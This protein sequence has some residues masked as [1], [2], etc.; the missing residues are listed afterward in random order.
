PQRRQFRMA[1]DPGVLGH[2]HFR[3]PRGDEEQIERSRRFAR[4]EL[5]LGSREIK[6]ALWMMNE[7]GPAISADQPLNRHARA[8]RAQLVSALAVTHA[9]DRALAVELRPALAQ[10][11]QRTFR[12]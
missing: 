6:R 1:R 10:S 4:R 2:D 11:P 3:V 7:H 12:Q 9:I 8:M 5:A